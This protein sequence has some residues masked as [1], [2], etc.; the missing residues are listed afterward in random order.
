VSIR[1]S[2]RTERKRAPAIE[3]CGRCVGVALCR[4]YLPLAISA[5]ATATS[6]RAARAQTAA[7]NGAPPPPPSTAPPGG[8]ADTYRASSDPLATRIS[9][10][11]SDAPLPQALYSISALAHLRLT[12]SPDDL[13]SHQRVS[14]S[15]T[16]VSVAAALQ[17]VLVNTGLRPIVMPDGGV[18]LTTRGPPQNTSRD[19]SGLVAA[20]QAI[21]GRV[22]RADGTPVKGATVALLGSADSTTTSDSGYFALR[23]IKPG[24]HMLVASG[25]GFLPVRMAVTVA[26]VSFTSVTVTMA[27]V[28]PVLSTVLT[29]AQKQSAYESVGFDRRMRAGVGQ[30]LTF[31]Q[32]EKRQAQKLSELLEGLRGILVYEHP[33]QFSGIVGGTRGPGSCV[34]FVIDGIPQNLLYSQDAQGSQLPPDDTDNLIVPSAIG[35]IEVYSS[36][37]RPRDFGVQEGDPLPAPADLIGAP[38]RPSTPPTVATPATQCVLVLIWTRNRLGIPNGS[39]TVRSTTPRPPT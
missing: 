33:R 22:V 9:V 23:N 12:Y 1:G 24:E 27:P 29:T 36:A 30:F 19:S 6:L 34:S 8:A 10:T 7:T 13:P 15:M 18:V 28:I 11:L 17:V 31:D 25:V 4:T 26:A 5:A 32:I 16:N 14:L 38:G 20:G 39:D 2:R 3:F 21:R 37:E 35:A